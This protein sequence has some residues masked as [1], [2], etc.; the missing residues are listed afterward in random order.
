MSDLLYE[1]QDHLCLLTL[2]RVSKHNAFDNQL[3]SEIHHQLDAAI[4]NSNV[5]VIVLKANGKHFSAGADLAWMQSMAHYNEEEN[6]KDAMVLGNLMYALNKS[7]KPTV[8]MVHGSAFGGGAGLAA[9]CDI[10]I[11]SQ[12][13]R[14]CFSEVKLGLI[15]AVISPYVVQAIGE[16]SAKALFMSAEVFD[17]AKALS[18][19]LVQHCVPEE[20]LLEF[21][22]NYAKQISNNAPN[23]VRA[24]KQL[25][26]YVVNKKINEEL[27]YYTAS[28][29]AQK[30]V[31]AE[32]QQ[33]LNA[34]LKKETP[35]WD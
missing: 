32:G 24:S 6:L 29:I 27:V 1:I 7:P 18:L 8:A 33:G 30:R 23:A 5:R 16:R 35:N 25:A 26:S 15:P 9:A 22:L 17:A 13:A 3:L 2:N 12:S 34:F 28:L 14:F 21:T 31:S 19:H 10:T 11:A 4:A 20:S